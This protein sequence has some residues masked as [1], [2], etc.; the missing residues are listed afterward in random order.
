MLVG[1]VNRQEIQLS[2]FLLK[3]CES[4]LYVV[5]TSPL[6][7]ICIVNNFSVSDLIVLFLMMSF[8]GVDNIN[9]YVV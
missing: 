4:S 3:N 5:D 1:F 7:N 2:V 9:F 6:S 8:D